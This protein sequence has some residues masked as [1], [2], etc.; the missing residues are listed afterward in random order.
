MN[1]AKLPQCRQ[2]KI[3]AY[4]G[5][6]HRQMGGRILWAQSCSIHETNL[7]LK[8]KQEYFEEII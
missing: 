7:D 6:K 4:N 1:D 5:Q 2:G 8:N 3:A